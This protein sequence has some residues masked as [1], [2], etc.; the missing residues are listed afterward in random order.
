M[1]F[2]QS[3]T[4]VIKAKCSKN[5]QRYKACCCDERCESVESSRTPIIDAI[6]KALL[7]VAV[8]EYRGKESLSSPIRP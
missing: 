6:Y 8:C 5:I 4:T 2:Q 3:T 1:Q 7:S